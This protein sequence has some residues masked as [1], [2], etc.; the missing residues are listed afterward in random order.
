MAQHVCGVFKLLGP[1]RLKEFFMDEFNAVLI[2]KAQEQY[3]AV[4]LVDCSLQDSLF[5]NH[6]MLNQQSQTAEKADG[7]GQLQKERV[8][9]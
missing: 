8:M 7:P 9:D 3:V 5:L 4:H 6:S 2:A 1:E